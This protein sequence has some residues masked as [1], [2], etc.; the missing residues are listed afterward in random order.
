M[1]DDPSK[2]KV[3]G[4]FVSGQDHEIDYVIA[5]LAKEYPLKTRS[6]IEAAVTTCKQ[7]I[8]PS[9]GREKLMACARKRLA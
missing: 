2:K 9:E 5:Q 4:W 6:Q 1:N 3:D 7:T 8:Q